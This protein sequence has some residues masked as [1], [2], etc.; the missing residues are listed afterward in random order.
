MRA[1]IKNSNTKRQSQ[2]NHDYNNAALSIY[3]VKAKGMRFQDIFRYLLWGG[4]IATADANRREYR[5]IT[6]WL[7]HLIYNTTALLLPDIVRILIPKQR[8]DLNFAEQLLVKM[9]RDNKNYAIY[10]SPLTIGYMLSHPRFNIYKG[11][12]AEIRVA[13]FGLDAIPHGATAFSLTMLLND[14]LR[15]AARLDKSKN[16]FSRL[17][18]WGS[19]NREITSFAGL[20]AATVVWEISEYNVHNYELAERGDVTKINMQWSVDDTARDVAANTIGWLIG[21]WLSKRRKG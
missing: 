1:C 2:L 20:I 8:R 19:R 13:G 6:P 12:M 7:P 18:D 9:V 16:W 3:S 11:D 4:L 10:V 5:M 21:S 14:G 15:T 17:L